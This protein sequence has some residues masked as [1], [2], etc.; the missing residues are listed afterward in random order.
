MTTRPF[1][2]IVVHFSLVF[3]GEIKDIKTEEYYKYLDVVIKCFMFDVF[4]YF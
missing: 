2:C 1:L 4:D 3:I